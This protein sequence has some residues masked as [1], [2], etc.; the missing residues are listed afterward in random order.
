LGE[1]IGDDSPVKIDG[2]V[3]LLLVDVFAGGVGHSL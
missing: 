1:K 3:E 2:V